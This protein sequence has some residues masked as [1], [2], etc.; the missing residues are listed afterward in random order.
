MFFHKQARAYIHVCW[1]F[2]LWV[3]GHCICYI[4]TYIYAL[5]CC[6]QNSMAFLW[7]Q[8]VLSCRIKPPP[9]KK[10]FFFLVFQVEL[11][12]YFAGFLKVYLTVLLLKKY[13]TAKI[14]KTFHIVFFFFSILWTHWSLISENFMIIQK[15]VLKLLDS[16]VDPKLWNSVSKCNFLCFWPLKNPFLN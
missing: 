7:F 12:L 11:H 10:K 1:L 6:C 13:L 3:L 9:P 4:G 15:H 8:G 5:G 2:I 14:E 16:Q